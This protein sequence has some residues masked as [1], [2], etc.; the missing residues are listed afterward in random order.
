M[1]SSR[2]R[3][4]LTLAYLSYFRFTKTHRGGSRTEVKKQRD[5]VYRA[6][7]IVILVSIG[8]IPV[9]WATREWGLVSVAT[10]ESIEAWKPVFW[11]ESIAVLSFGVAWAVKGQALLPDPDEDGKKPS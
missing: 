8:L 4:S 11:L 6:A 5:R 1:P 10:L 2:G 9:L 3:C 7:G